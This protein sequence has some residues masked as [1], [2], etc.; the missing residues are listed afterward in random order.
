MAIVALLTLSNCVVHKD[1]S[2]PHPKLAAL[3]VINRA[4]NGKEATQCVVRAIDGKLVVLNEKK[5]I[6]L[7]PGNRKVS[8][9]YHKWEKKGT[10]Q[11]VSF[12]P[13]CIEGQF[14]AGG[15]YWLD[16]GTFHIEP[17]E[18][19]CSVKVTDG[20]LVYAVNGEVK[21]RKVN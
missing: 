19:V 8:F 13:I 11:F 1:P 16:V 5:F 14:K 9:T 15:V 10:K 21:V 12:K 3:R 7:H 17:V 6:L 4:G 18:G 2:I 20:H